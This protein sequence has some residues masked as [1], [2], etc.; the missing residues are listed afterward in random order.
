MTNSAHCSSTF[1]VS[2]HL[3]ND[4]AWPFFFSFLCCLLRI[5]PTFGLFSLSSGLFTVLIFCNQR[6][7]IRNTCSLIMCNKV[8]FFFLPSPKVYSCCSKFCRLASSN[9]HKSVLHTL[10][11]FIILSVVKLSNV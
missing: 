11:L 7:C 6:N 3:C 9:K 8:V 5:V 2:T 4:K 10:F 1:S